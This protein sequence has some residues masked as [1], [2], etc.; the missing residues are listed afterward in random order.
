MYRRIAYDSSMST[1]V[2]SAKETVSGIQAPVELLSSAGSLVAIAVIAAAA[3][4]AMARRRVEATLLYARGM[5]PF[6]IGLKTALESLLPVVAGT[7]LG[8]AAAVRSRPVP[9]AGRGCGQRRLSERRRRPSRCGF[10]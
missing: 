10:P 3:A 6:S 8:L 2:S 4:F 7:A 5:S 9:R 1:V